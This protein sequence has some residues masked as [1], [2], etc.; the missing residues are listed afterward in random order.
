MEKN[1]INSW[2][3]TWNPSRFQW[4]NFEDGYNATIQEIKQLGFSIMR[5]SC[6]NTKKIRANDQIYL[7]RIGCENKG[8]I[9]KG[10]AVSDVF[11][12]LHW[13]SDMAKNGKK[14][15]RVFVRF[16]SIVDLS[17]NPPLSLEI[18]KNH[19]PDM[20]WTPQASGIAIPE[21]IR[22]KL[23]TLWTECLQSQTER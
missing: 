6:G 22:S 7:I 20:C 11:E 14:V 3:F 9:A 15:K 17:K 16:E 4:N 23:D 13:D 19:F 12:G 18:L 2:L 21:A 10:T 8:I 1:E 5:W